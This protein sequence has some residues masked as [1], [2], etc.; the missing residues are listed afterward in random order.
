MKWC[1]E[2]KGIY[3]NDILENWKKAWEEQNGDGYIKGLVSEIFEMVVEKEEDNKCK[4]IGF[5][6]CFLG[7]H[8]IALFV[9]LVT[10][11]FF[12]CKGYSWSKIFGILAFYIVIAVWGSAVVSKWIDIKK[13]QETWARHSRHHHEMEREMLLF[14]YGMPPY[15]RLKNAK[16][17]FINNMLRIWSDNQERF[18]V[19]METKEKRLTEDFMEHI[20]ALPKIKK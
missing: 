1:D 16:E 10:E 6:L 15:E 8:G 5:K 13:Y 19:N 17:I 4:N 12:A 9:T 14:C 3:Q 20:T 11:I 7:I 2:K 18:N